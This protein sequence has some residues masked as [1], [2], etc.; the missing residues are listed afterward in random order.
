MN[1][2]AM[3]Q[4]AKSAAEDETSAAPHAARTRNS[5]LLWNHQHGSWFDFVWL[6]Y[7]VFFIFEPVQ[8]GTRRGWI[9]FGIV[10]ALFLVCYTG[11]VRARGKRQAYL[12]LAG[13]AVLG[14]LWFPSNGGAAGA[15]V[16]V[17][18]FAPFVLESVTACLVL[19]AAVDL[20]VIA[21]G[22]YFHVNPWSWG[23]VV[24]M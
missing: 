2:K 10:Y 5:A 7:S 4:R 3:E 13:M 16:Y 17:T 19:F 23:I 9:R 8:E 18:A 24:L 6:V 14:F 11:I 12:F 1:T 20:G 21:E 15:I 22:L